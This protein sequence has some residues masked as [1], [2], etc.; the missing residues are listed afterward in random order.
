MA[1]SISKKDEALPSGA[2][3]LTRDI[4]LQYQRK[5]IEKWEPLSEV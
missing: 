1:L 4:A 2:V 5:L 3:R